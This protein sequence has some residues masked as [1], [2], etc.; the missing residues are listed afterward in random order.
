MTVVLNPPLTHI[1]EYR[2]ADAEA[3][4]RMWRESSS[5]W[6][7]GGPGG[8]DHSTA[9]RVMQD[10]RDLNT[11]ATFIAFLP[12]PENGE[13]RAV[14]YCSLFEYTAERDTAY[15]GTLS[16]HPDWHGKGVG[17][18]LLRVALERSVALGYSRLDLNT[19]A[20]NLK[21]V[22]LYKKSGYFWVP[23][24]TV[25]MENYLPL[26][27]RIPAAQ[28]F[29]RRADWYRDFQ[30]DLSVRED[31]E[32]VGKIGVYVYAWEQEGRRLKV[33]IDRRA[34]GITALETERYAVSA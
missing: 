20:G 18:D 13:E 24:T 21:A 34:K 3:V 16:A 7:G 6:P 32:K 15:V 28:E 31:D 33:V 11:L 8:G 26:I 23:D 2:D 19:W 30:R 4:A 10:Q 25:K 29:F 27:F 22:P 14:G 1:R 5:A 12:D 17:R 9:A